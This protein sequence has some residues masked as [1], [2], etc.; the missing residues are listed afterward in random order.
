MSTNGAAA[1]CLAVHV[2][3]A[4]WP[5]LYLDGRPSNKTREFHIGLK[6]HLLLKPKA[7]MAIRID[8]IGL[9]EPSV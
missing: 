9:V 1:M 7:P 3:K 2:N 8:N 6:E 4:V 5:R